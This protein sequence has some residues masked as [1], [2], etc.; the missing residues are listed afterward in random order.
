MY[1]PPS[2]NIQPYEDLIIQEAMQRQK[3]LNNQQLISPERP[4]SRGRYLLSLALV[5]LFVL[6]L[7]AL[8]L[9]FLYS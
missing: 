1:M 5:A 4:T 3:Q 7:V 8:A 9:F 6:V 2:Q